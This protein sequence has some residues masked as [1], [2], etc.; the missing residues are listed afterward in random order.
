MFIEH[1]GSGPGP[2]RAVQRLLGRPWRYVFDGCCLDRDTAATIAATGFADVQIEPYRFGGVFVPV[3]P[4]ISG[5][6]VA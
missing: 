4:Q 1:V 6:A 3:W 5:V 2:I